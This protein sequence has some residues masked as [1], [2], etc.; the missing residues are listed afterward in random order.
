MCGRSKSQ[1]LDLFLSSLV[2]A[3][4]VIANPVYFLRGSTKSW[5][6]HYQ[7]VVRLQT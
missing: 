5:K 7:V 1:L 4:Q 6:S 2:I 3:V